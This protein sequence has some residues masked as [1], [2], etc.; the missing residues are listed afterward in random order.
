MTHAGTDGNWL[1]EDGTT[2]NTSA[3][4]NPYLFTARRWD[5][6]TQLYYYRFR[7]YSPLIGRFLQPD[8]LGYIDGMNM[9]AY[10]GN[11]PVNFVDPWGVCKGG[12][13]SGGWPDRAVGVGTVVAVIGS[14]MIGLS[15]ALPI[16][17][18]GETGIAILVGGGVGTTVAGAGLGIAG[19]FGVDNVIGNA[20]N[21]AVGGVIE[22]AENAVNSVTD[23]VINSNFGREWQYY[24]DNPEKMLDDIIGF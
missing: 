15:S 24:E 10:C 19:A 7:D 2:I 17:V 1:T 16:E 6:Y 12:G 11:N 20:V 22:G 9:Y 3:V 18:I 21:D 23:A 8:P 13:P 14:L 5:F 4:G